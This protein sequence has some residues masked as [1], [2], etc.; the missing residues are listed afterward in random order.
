MLAARLVDF[1]M[2]GQDVQEPE[3]V[4]AL[5]D[6]MVHFVQNSGA[7]TSTIP[8]TNRLHFCPLTREPRLPA[9]H[10]A[11]TEHVCVG[12]DVQVP[13]PTDMP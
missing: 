4:T 2:S 9:L 10:A 12:A 6:P 8:E 11:F 13:Y 1:P 5:Y 3:P 7:F